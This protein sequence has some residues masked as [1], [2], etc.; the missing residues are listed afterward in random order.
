MILKINHIA[1]VTPALEEGVGFWTEALG[2]HLHAQR[3][4]PAEGVDIAFLPVGESEVELIAPFVEETGVARYLAKRGPG[5]HHICFDVDDLDEALARL[6]AHQVPLI[7]ETPRVNA[8][9]RRM[10]FIHPKGTGGVLVE[11]YEAEARPH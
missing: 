5:I 2:L 10:V 7:D 3:R 8:A 9:G 11:L 6:K 1:I 4:E